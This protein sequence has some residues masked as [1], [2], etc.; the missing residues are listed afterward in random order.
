MICDGAESR[1]TLMVDMDIGATEWEACS[2]SNDHGWTAWLDTVPGCGD[3]RTVLRCSQIDDD[4]SIWLTSV[5]NGWNR[6]P[7]EEKIQECR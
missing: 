4:F 3:P 1:N 2:S 7:G 5:D 6:W